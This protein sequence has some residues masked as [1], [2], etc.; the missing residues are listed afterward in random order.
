[1]QWAGGCG[2]EHTE[3][4][5]SYKIINEDESEIIRKVGKINWWLGG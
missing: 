5:A 2:V 3:R 4:A 1:M